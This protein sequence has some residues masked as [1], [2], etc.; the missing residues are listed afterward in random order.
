[1]LEKLEVHF[2]YAHHVNELP[3]K[4]NYHDKVQHYKH[5]PEN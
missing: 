5:C 2:T 4:K 3:K 1:M